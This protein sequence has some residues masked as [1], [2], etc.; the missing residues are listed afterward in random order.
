MINARNNARNNARISPVPGHCLLVT[1][2]KKKDSVH[3]KSTFI[4]R[5]YYLDEKCFLVIRALDSHI[6]FIIK[7]VLKKLNNSV[8][9]CYRV[10]D[11]CRE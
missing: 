6:S 4:T 9:N 7:N 8:T 5:G 11:Q 3:T 1:Y 2:K 10:N